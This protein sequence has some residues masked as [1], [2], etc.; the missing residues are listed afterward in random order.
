MTT[1]DLTRAALVEA[2]PTLE[3]ELSR[4]IAANATISG[5]AAF[6]VPMDAERHAP[7]YV[8]IAVHDTSGVAVSGV[9]ESPRPQPR[10]THQDM[11]PGILNALGSVANVRKFHIRRYADKYPERIKP[12]KR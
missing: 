5:W 8:K 7:N 1:K 9:I 6:D 10:D 2:V 11:Q 3:E 4:P 12:K